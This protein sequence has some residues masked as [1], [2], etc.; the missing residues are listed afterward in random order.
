VDPE[1]PGRSPYEIPATSGTGACLNN[2]SCA[3][4]PYEGP[5]PPGDYEANTGDLSDPGAVGDWLRNRL[6]DW[7]D[8]RVP[9]TPADGT[10]TQ[11]RDGFFLHGG[12]DPGSA[13]CVDVGGGETGDSTT[14]RLLGDLKSDPD[15]VVPVTVLP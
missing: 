14:D 10:D 15:G 3:D 11:G 8:W 9:L 1:Q 5:I 2:S 12:E 4:K 13:G 6:G 7:G